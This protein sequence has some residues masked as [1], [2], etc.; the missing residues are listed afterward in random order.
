MSSEMSLNGAKTFSIMTINKM[1]LNKPTLSI[2]TINT[3]T[4]SKN[5]VSIM[6]LIMTLSTS[7]IK[8]INNHHNSIMFALYF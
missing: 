6:N 1:T 7:D 3:I 4:I 8:K 5:I 2:I